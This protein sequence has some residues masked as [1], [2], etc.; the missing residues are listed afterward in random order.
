MASLELRSNR[1]RIVFRFAGATFQTPLKT[2]DAKE[3][4]AC[5]SRLAE[6]LRLVEWGRLVPPPD[7]DLPTF[8]L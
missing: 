4:S 2:T 6:N 8:L 1:Y 7:A 5:L 3:A